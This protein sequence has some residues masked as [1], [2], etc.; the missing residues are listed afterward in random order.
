[1]TGPNRQPTTS[2]LALLLCMAALWPV[3][4]LASL[5][6]ITGRSTVGCNSCHGSASGAAY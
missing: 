6:G 4:A 5:N 3:P 1:M 2:I